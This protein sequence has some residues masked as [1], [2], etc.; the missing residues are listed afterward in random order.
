MSFD[1]I[2]ENGSSTETEEDSS[3]SDN[4]MDISGMIAQINAGKDSKVTI[5]NKADAWINN[6][7][8]L[9]EGDL[10]ITNSGEI[11]TVTRGLFTNVSMENKEGSYLG[12][13]QILLDGWQGNFLASSEAW[14]VPYGQGLQILKIM[15]SNNRNVTED[16][17]KNLGWTKGQIVKTLDYLQ[18]SY[19]LGRLDYDM[20]Q[21]NHEDQKQQFDQIKNL[22]MLFPMEAAMRGSRDYTAVKKEEFTKFNLG[23]GTGKIDDIAKEPFLPDEYYKKNY[24]PMQGTPGSRMDF[25]RLGSSGKIEKSRV[26]YDQAGKQK[27]RIDYSDHGNSDHHTNPHMHDTFIKMQG[28]V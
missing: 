2:I 4:S 9:E 10:D 12:A 18:R 21:V 8:S 14:G 26:I 7:S 17:L 25:S 27:Y 16:D 28:K 5:T 3:E 6:I 11:G 1:G 22:L 24:A 23:K 19:T 20:V 15:V 13:E